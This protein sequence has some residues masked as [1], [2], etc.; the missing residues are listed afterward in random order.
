MSGRTA[1]GI[2][3][4]ESRPQG[5][6]WEAWLGPAP[7]VPYNRNRAF[8]R[9]RWFYDY[10]GGQITNFGTHYLDFSHWALDANA[11]LA[12]TAMGAKLAVQDNRE[13]PDTAEVMWTYPGGALVTFSQ[14]NTNASPADLRGSTIEVR[15]TAG[16][17]FLD[18]NGYEVTPE[19]VCEVDF[20][21]STPLD[22]SVDDAWRNRRHTLIQA[23]KVEGK[24]GTPLHARNFLD[25]VRSRKACNCDI[26][27]GH[28][29]TSATLIADVA[30]KTKSYLEWD[31]R[32]ECFTNKSSANKYLRYEYRPPYHFPS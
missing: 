14:F 28:R 29:S 24:D 2:L 31:A 13:I 3:R 15:G 12:V 9:F 1:S 7:K 17:M 25:C 19:A 11:P 23:K 16:T 6:D 30:L 4:T 20:P 27:T 32:Q 22:R 26:E 18:W 10:S 21:A 5:L 8:Y